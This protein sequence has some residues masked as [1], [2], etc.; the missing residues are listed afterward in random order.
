MVMMKEY[1]ILL[2]K[3]TLMLPHFP[4]AAITVEVSVALP[5]PLQYGGCDLTLFLLGFLM[6]VSLLRGV[7][8]PPPP[9][10][11]KSKILA[12]VL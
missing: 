6:D 7:N 12:N 5:I 10:P 9:P 1:V 3:I 11:P 8:L 4:K 2:K